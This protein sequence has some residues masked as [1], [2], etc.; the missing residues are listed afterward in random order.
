MLE[1]LEGECRARHVTVVREGT[2]PTHAPV[3]LD[4]ESLKQV[5]LNLV[6][7]GVEAM[8]EGGTLRVRTITTDA[9]IEVRL[10]DTG[11]GFPP[12]LL[13]RLG[14]PFVTT[15]AQ[16]SGLGLFLA[17]RMVQLAGGALALRNGDQG[18]AE[19][20]VQFPLVQDA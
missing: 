12:E 1:L 17:R 9:A 11:K 15:K 19:C 13:A 5:W 7:N 14:S 3:T 20:T 18:G 6:L 8:P 2:T 10:A 4:N 16:G